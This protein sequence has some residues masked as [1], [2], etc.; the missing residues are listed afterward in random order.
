MKTDALIDLTRGETEIEIEVPSRRT[1]D[2]LT[3]AGSLPG[4]M[5]EIR[6]PSLSGLLRGLG[7]LVIIVAF[8]IFLFKGWRDGD[9]LSRYL[10]LIGHS[11]ILSLAGFASGHL[12]HEGK[13]ARLFIALALAAV[14]DHAGLPDR[15]D[16]GSG[17]RLCGAATVG[18]RHGANRRLCR[19]G[20]FGRRGFLLLQ[21]RRLD[22]AGAGG[23]GDRSRR[24]P[25]RA[26]RPTNQGRHGRLESS[27]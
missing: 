26:S 9:E 18:L 24:V 13:G 14:P 12:L 27:L 15:R 25:D 22:R 5:G 10:L 1:C 20:L 17:V 8:V 23:C 6:V 11:L 2:P 16:R 7:G 19:L 21:H 3:G 4:R